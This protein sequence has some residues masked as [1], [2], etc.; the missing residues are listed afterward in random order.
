VFDT[1]DTDTDEREFLN[2]KIRG[3]PG[4]EYSGKRRGEGRRSDFFAREF[5]LERNSRGG[6]N[7]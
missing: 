6:G 4:R 5:G 7:Q 1:P 2:E 3:G